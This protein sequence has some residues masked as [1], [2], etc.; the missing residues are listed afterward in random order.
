MTPPQRHMPVQPPSSVTLAL[1]YWPLIIGACTVLGML[2]GA[3]MAWQNLKDRVNTL[4]RR[5]LYYHGDSDL[6]GAI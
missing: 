6:K 1:E 4:E 5:D 2:L 3:S